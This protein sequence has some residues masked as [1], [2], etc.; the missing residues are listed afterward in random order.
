MTAT[1][2]EISAR[3]GPSSLN[4]GNGPSACS[5]PR[6]R[7]GRSARSGRRPTTIASRAANVVEAQPAEQESGGPSPRRRRGRPRSENG[8]EGEGAQSGCDARRSR[9]PGRLQERQLDRTHREFPTSLMVSLEPRTTPVARMER[10]GMRGSPWQ[11]DEAIPGLHFVPSSLRSGPPSLVSLEPRTTLRSGGVVTMRWSNSRIA[12]R[13]IRATQRTALMV[14][15]SPRSGEPR[16]THYSGPRRS[17]SQAERRFPERSPDVGPSLHGSRHKYA[18]QAWLQSGCRGFRPARPEAP[19]SFERT[20]PVSRT[21][22]RNS[23]HAAWLGL[24]T[25]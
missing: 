12:L 21:R 19:R 2:M 6:I 22:S 13:S 16:T 24:G 5:G 23:S 9:R 17:F 20:E 7:N 18:R 4:A 8:G 25:S 15:C 11:W 14:R 1:I 10:S 3:T